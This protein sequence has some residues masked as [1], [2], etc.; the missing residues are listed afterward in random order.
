MKKTI[1]ANG[2]YNV[3]QDIHSDKCTI[4]VSGVDG[5]AT[6][7]LVAFNTEGAE[8]PIVD[9]T[10]TAI[11]VTVGFQEALAQGADKDLFLKVTGA[12][13]TTAISVETYP[14]H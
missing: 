4:Y 10:G 12:T 11:M 1:K 6:M 14:L 9:S 5:G 7:A 3:T 8:Y 2:V 13:G